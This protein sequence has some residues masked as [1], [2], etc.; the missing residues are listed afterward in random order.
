MAPPSDLLKSEFAG[1]SFV[2]L[3]DTFF[4]AKAEEIMV[5]QQVDREVV[6]MSSLI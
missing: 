5:T 2:P 3:A 6:W 4:F 1:E